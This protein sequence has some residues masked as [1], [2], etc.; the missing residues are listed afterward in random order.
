MASA[1]PFLEFFFAKIPEEMGVG[2]SAAGVGE[3]SK[4]DGKES[5]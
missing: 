4:E 5:E 3:K 2:D 1:L